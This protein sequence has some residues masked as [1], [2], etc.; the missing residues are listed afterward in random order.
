WYFGE[1]HAHTLHSD[2]VNEVS[3]L[4]EK[5][6]ALGIDFVALTDH[7]T[8]SGLLELDAAKHDVVFIPGCELTTFHGHHPI[9]GVKELVP[10]HE[11]GRVLALEELAPR[12]RAQGGL[13]SVAHPFK[14]GDPICTGCRMR[15]GLD[16]RSF[17][18]FEVWYR[19][20]DAAESDNEAAYALWNRY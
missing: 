12:V 14:L 10:W 3:E 18:L 17:D 16:P 6:R 5:A 20:W 11:D 9:Y 13:I 4:A 15:D 7:N 19:R 8:M 1:M 2:G